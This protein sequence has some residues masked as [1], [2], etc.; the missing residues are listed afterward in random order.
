MTT[1]RTDVAGPRSVPVWKWLGLAFLAVPVLVVALFAVGEGIGGEEGWWGHL[2]QLAIAAALVAGAW[3]LPKVFGPLLVVLGIAPVIA[4]L[5]AGAPVGV[6]S[7]SILVVWL[8]LVLSGV[9]FTVAG[10]R[11]RPSERPPEA[12]ES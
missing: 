9:F 3:L 7:G 10:Y 5:V 1:L 2:I 6:V 11:H 12:D 8:P 4:M